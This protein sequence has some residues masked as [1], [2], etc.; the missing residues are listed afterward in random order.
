MG[1][2]AVLH[3]DRVI[4]VK[5]RGDAWVRGAFSKHASPC[6]RVIGRTFRAPL[7][8]AMPNGMGPPARIWA[9]MPG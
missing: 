7:A 2:P 9:R 4:R 8:H 5:Q 6:R 3:R 1:E